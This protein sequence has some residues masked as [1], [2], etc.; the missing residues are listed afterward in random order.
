MLKAWSAPRTGGC[1]DVHVFGADATTLVHIGQTALGSGGT[2]DYLVEPV[3]SDLTLSES[4]KVAALDAM[5][6]MRVVA[7]FSGR[8]PLPDRRSGPSLEGRDGPVACAFACLGA[9]RTAP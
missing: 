1:R 8:S 5:D 2:I 3:F 9:V 4:Y 6:E 7:R